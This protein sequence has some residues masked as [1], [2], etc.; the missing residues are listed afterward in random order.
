MAGSSVNG[1][2]SFSSNVP[3]AV[4]ALRGFTNERSEFLI[5]TLPVSDLAAPVP[6]GETII[7]PH[8]AEGGGWK[9]QVVLVNPTD[10]AL[11]GNVQFFTPAGA[12]ATLTIDGQSGSSFPYS[13]AARSSRRFQSSGLGATQAGSIRII[14]SASNR[15]PSGLVIFTYK[16]G[17]TTVSEAGVPALRTGNAFRLYAEASGNFDASQIGSIETGIAIA[18]ASSSAATVTFELTRLDGTSTGLTGTTT[19]PGN[20]QTALFMNQIAGFSSM[21]NPATP[22]QGVLRISSSSAAIAVVGLRGRYNERRDF[23][24][25]TTAPVDESSSPPTTELFFPHL[26]DS[27]GYTTQFV[28]FSGSAGQASTGTLRLFSQGGQPFNLS[29]R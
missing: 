23:L 17:A 22:F 21:G 4:V 12:A 28:L 16:G 19:V 6:I 9:T 13:I 1:T 8:F 25:T 14:P 5:T 29:L 15:T 3:V 2:F 11:T 27:G 10:S 26:A 24:I 18:N 7:F 20:G